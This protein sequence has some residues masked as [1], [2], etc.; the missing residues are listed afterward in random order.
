VLNL[1]DDVF[2]ELAHIVIPI[3]NVLALLVKLRVFSELYSPQIILVK[4]NW[5]S[6]LGS[7]GLLQEEISRPL[8]SLNSTET[9]AYATPAGGITPI[10]ERG[11][12]VPPKREG[13]GL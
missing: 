5:Q 7:G 1:N 12:E 10:G 9:S 11:P 3:I 13:D 6:E 4:G 8:E 2:Q